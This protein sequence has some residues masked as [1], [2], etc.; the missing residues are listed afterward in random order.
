MGS[1]EIDKYIANIKE[2]L[3][4]FEGETPQDRLLNALARVM[5]YLDD[6]WELQSY[7]DAQVVFEEVKRILRGTQVN[8][9]RK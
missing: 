2:D 4:K 5:M 7:A 6:F 9:A 1:S 3:S 8:P